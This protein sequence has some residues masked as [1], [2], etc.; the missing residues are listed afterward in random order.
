MNGKTA[1]E[2]SI[3]T[4]KPYSSSL[5]KDTSILHNSYRI[6]WQVGWMAISNVH[7]MSKGHYNMQ[8]SL[9]DQKFWKNYQRENT[10]ILSYLMTVMNLNFGV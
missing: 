6:F 2:E 4:F 8:F 10:D 5:T 9:L 3:L 7:K 1:F